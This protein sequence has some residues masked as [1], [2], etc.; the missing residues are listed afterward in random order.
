MTRPLA[1][2]LFE[3][4][5][6]LDVAGPLS[7]FETA[8]LLEPRSYE[9]RVCAAQAG[10]VRSSS[11]AVMQATPLPK[12]ERID[13]LLVVGGA[14]VRQAA[15]CARLRRIVRSTYARGSRVASICSGTY[16]L[17]A[18]GILD[19]KRAT[20][21]WSRSRDFTARFPRVELEPDRIY[22]N[23]DNVWS[24]AGVTAGID[25]ALALITADLGERIARQVAQELVVYYRRPG[26]QSQFSPLLDERAGGRF[27]GLLDYVRSNL[28]AELS[29]QELAKRAAMSPRHFSRVFAQETGVAPAKAVQRI[30]VEAARVLLE[31][32]GASVKETAVR[33]GFGNAEHLRRSLL[34]HRSPHV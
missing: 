24:S 13:T 7:A 31:E 23:A 21:H 15:T 8:N 28:T 12:P 19:G 10:L 4:F 11:G 6:I 22:V 33:C 14:G 3:D 18:S 2:V 9:L 1:L 32:R 16:V 26:G 20:T 17:A 25:L 29:V 30:R 34:R 5:Q 27:E